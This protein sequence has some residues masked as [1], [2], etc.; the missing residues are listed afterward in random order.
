LG[1]S[2][3]SAGQSL[4]RRRFRVFFHEPSAIV[5]IARAAGLEPA[6]ARRGFFWQLLALERA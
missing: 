5:A 6:L 2:L 4:F 1:L 3:V